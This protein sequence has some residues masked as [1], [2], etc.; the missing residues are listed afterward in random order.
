[1]PVFA[2]VWEPTGLRRAEGMSEVGAALAHPR[3]MVWIDADEQNREM[4]E[5]LERRLGVHPLVIE[6][7]FSERTTPKV[8]DYGEYLYVIVHGVRRDAE[9]P[10]E[11]ET[12]ELDLLIGPNWILT[13]HSRPLRSIEE[14]TTDLE[15][16]P[17]LLE[18]GPA[19]IAHG[20]IDRMTDHYLPV[21]DRFEEEIDA[22]EE[23]IVRDPRPE[24]LQQ[25]FGMKRSLQR[26]RRISTYQRDLL[27]RLS[28]SEFSQIP[29]PALPFF[30][31]LYDHFVRIAD[32]ADSYR[33]LVTLSLEIYMSVL[34]NRQNEVMKALALISTIMLP[35]NLLAAIYGMNFAHLP[36]AGT[37]AGFYAILALMLT[38]AAVLRW[39]FK[40][41]RWL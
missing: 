35:L 12:V 40:R 27:Q 3:A 14:M 26:L 28:R 13:H 5:F 38:L 37:N 7:M 18:R 9:G 16:N 41:R 17:R 39:T 15:R 10:T 2:F 36:L 20:V 11:L 1:M 6:D 21:V 25:L 34:A 24:M 33:E 19:Y 31:D 4:E 32:L 29:Q 8:E 22:I 23:K 30:R